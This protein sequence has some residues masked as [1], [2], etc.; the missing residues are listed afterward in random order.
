MTV[1]NTPQIE[2][3]VQKA[4]VDFTKKVPHGTTA[5]TQA[6]M[7]SL[8]NL[9]DDNG[10]YVYGPKCNNLDPTITA[11][12][13]DMVWFTPMKLPY[14]SVENIIFDKVHLVLECEWKRD[15]GD[16]MYDFQKLVQARADHRVM[17]FESYETDSTINN[18]IQY[19]ESSPL[20]VNGDRYLIAALRAEDWTFNF[21]SH[22]KS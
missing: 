6:I 18:M 15:I 12:L 11:C 3:D 20:S 1:K 5:R 21:K 10:Y 13:Y 8:I 22:V 17:I 14:L 19:V 7:N 2:Q 4:L 9:A 16:I